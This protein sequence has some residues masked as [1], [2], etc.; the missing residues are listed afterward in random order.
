MT[1]RKMFGICYFYIKVDS[2]SGT[3]CVVSKCLTE[4]NFQINAE[5][6]NTVLSHDFPRFIFCKWN[7]NINTR[8]FSVCQNLG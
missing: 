1:I 7:I 8:L 4:R 3:V 6:E 5:P 2:I